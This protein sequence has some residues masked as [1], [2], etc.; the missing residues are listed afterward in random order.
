MPF[1]PSRLQEKHDE[2]GVGFTKYILK[3]PVVSCV[4]AAQAKGIPL[5][6]ELK[7]LILKTCL[8]YLALHLPGD[9]TA[10]L[11]KVKKILKVKQASLAAPENLQRL[12]MKP[13]T[14]SAIINPT[15]S[16]PH[17]V[18]V[19]LFAM[20][21]LSTNSGSTRHYYIFSPLVFLTADKVLFGEF[22]QEINIQYSCVS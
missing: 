9:A 12:G 16:M 10:S 2:P 21:Y 7:T 4:E 5:K 22:E 1:S 3:K 6:N 8:G 13:G 18:S 17:L 14:V 11:R 19:K 15:W 20:N